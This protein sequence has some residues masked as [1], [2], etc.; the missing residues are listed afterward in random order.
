M[1]STAYTLMLSCGSKPETSVTNST[2][3]V[4]EPSQFKS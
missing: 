3:V 1:I 2:C 4:C